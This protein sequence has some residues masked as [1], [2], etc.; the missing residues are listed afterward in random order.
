LTIPVKTV[1]NNSYQVYDIVPELLENDFYVHAE[2]VR[3]D[4][5]DEVKALQRAQMMMQLRVMSREDVMESV[6]QVQDTQTQIAKMDIE[7]V[8]ATIPE[9]KLKRAIK[10]YK[11]RG[12]EEEAS[13][14]EEHLALIEFQRRSQIEQMFTQSQQGGMPP[15]GAA[16]GGMPPEEVPPK[17]V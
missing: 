14:A 16:P 10:I 3:Q 9:L 6:M 17:E 8:E 11:E 5:Y 13:M 4:V 1:L 7:D 15:E 2:L 12:M